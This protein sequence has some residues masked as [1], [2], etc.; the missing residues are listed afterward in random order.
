MTVQPEY[1]T[2]VADML[3]QLPLGA[4]LTVKSGDKINT[5][6][7]GWGSI[8]YIWNKP[9]MM[10]MVRYSR[11]THELIKDAP[12]FS[13]SVPLDGHLKKTLAG[14]G[15]KS[16]R[17]IDKFEA[18]DL[19]AKPARSIASPVIDNCGLIYECRVLY[20]HPMDPAAF[21]AVLD[22]KLYKT[23]DYHVLYYGEIVAN[24]NNRA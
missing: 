22:S 3:K 4:F 19:A 8:G 13:V 21:D 6:T 12:D 23:K 24:Y 5:M 7:I 15:S 17:D 20:K 2:G 14:A 10:V 18:F 16:G 11:Y 9:I 1:I